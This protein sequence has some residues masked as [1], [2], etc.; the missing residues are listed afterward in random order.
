MQTVD[1]NKLAVL[2]KNCPM[3][4]KPSKESLSD[5]HLS[6]EVKTGK[7]KHNV[8]EK[9]DSNRHKTSES[10][11]KSSKSGEDDI[12]ALLSIKTAKEEGSTKISDEIQELLNTSSTKEIILAKNFR[13]MGGS[14]VNIYRF[15]LLNY[16]ILIG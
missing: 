4:N 9:K 5:L 1:R 7:R 14:Q 10:K 3:V 16:K 8:L 15:K 11:I 6:A 2:I 13:S 12:E